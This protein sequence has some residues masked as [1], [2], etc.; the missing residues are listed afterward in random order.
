MNRTTQWLFETPP[1]LRS[2]SMSAS[3]SLELER[4]WLFE[5]PVQTAPTLIGSESRPPFSTLYLNLGIG[6]SPKPDRS[7]VCPLPMTGVFLPENYRFTPQVDLI[8]YLQGHHRS[9]VQPSKAPAPGYYPSSLTI[10]QYWNQGFYPFFAFRE[11]VNASGKNVILVAPTLG[12]RSEAGTLIQG[13]GFDTYIEQVLAAIRTYYAPS[14]MFDRPLSL[15]NLILAC[16]SGGGLPMRHIATS[17][18][19]YAAKIRECWGFDC[20][21]NTGDDTHWVQ[22]AK[23]NPS[24]RLSIYYIANSQT[25]RLSTRLQTYAKQQKLANV[26]VSPSSTGDHNKVPIAHWMHRIK[27]TPFLKNQAEVTQ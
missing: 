21:Y 25:A 8:L 15:G 27:S 4:D 9:P 14:M 22:W 3:P 5:T 7:K 2:N 1:T 18:A 11:G 20:T 6:C 17:K 23:R 26:L 12:P 16:H 19:S 24:S 10:N 13:N